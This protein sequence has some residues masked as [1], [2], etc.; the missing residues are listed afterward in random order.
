MY[1]DRILGA[2]LP[3]LLGGKQTHYSS[4]AFKI[5]LVVIPALA[6]AD[7]RSSASHRVSFKYVCV[8]SSTVL[9]HQALHGL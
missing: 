3:L 9:I 5:S 6:A 2:K 4:L 1:F 7:I 8:N